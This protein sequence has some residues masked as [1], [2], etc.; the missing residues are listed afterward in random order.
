[1]LRQTH[2]WK[3]LLVRLCWLNRRGGGEEELA[4][5]GAIGEEGL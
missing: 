1:M 4:E 2:Y 5:E 3:I